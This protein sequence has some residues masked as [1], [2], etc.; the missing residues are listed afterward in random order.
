MVIP[1][2]PRT[3]PRTSDSSFSLFTPPTPRFAPIDQP[4]DFYRQKKPVTKKH[5][6]ST[7]FTT[8][9]TKRTT[10]LA[11]TIVPLTPNETPV[12]RKRNQDL[13]D[14]LLRTPNT[15]T[16]RILFPSNSPVIGSGRVR[17]GHHRSHSRDMVK[18]PQVIPVTPQSQ[19]P[20]RII[21]S[22]PRPVTSIARPQPPFQV[23]NDHE[24]FKKE[25]DNV[26]GPT[27]T[28]TTASS[29]LSTKNTIGGRHY[30]RP[31]TT[32][33]PHK[34]L[35]PDVPGMWYI[36]RGKKVFRPFPEGDTELSDIK[37]RKLFANVQ[38]TKRGSGPTS[39]FDHKRAS[40]S[41]SAP[42]S[43]RSSKAA[44]FLSSSLDADDPFNSEEEDTDLDDDYKSE[45]LDVSNHGSVLSE[46][47]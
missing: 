11:P 12:H 26:I 23:F 45:L 37:P 17:G 28:T 21:N 6:P 43:E 24:A 15:S 3:P 1:A 31:S 7:Q 22:I 13:V 29:S 38:P 35:P 44:P 5:D 16:S 18:R 41:D 42:R 46:H 30:L 39:V 9:H 36:F 2:T 10:K 14:S 47:P 27:S 32:S 19:K 4:D 40:R 34:S 20:K 8:P 25:A 33:H